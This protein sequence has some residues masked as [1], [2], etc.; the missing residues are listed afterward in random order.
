[1]SLLGIQELC[2]EEHQVEGAVAQNDERISST[3]AARDLMTGPLQS[4]TNEQGY[5]IVIFDQKQAQRFRHD[6]FTG[7]ERERRIPHVLISGLVGGFGR[8]DDGRFF[9]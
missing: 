8:R 2:F 6:S 1:M 4:F 9:D 3:A 5:V 7:P